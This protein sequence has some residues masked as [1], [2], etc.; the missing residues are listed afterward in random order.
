MGNRCRGWLASVIPTRWALAAVIA[1]AVPVSAQAPS[2]DFGV[3]MDSWHLNVTDV[4]G[5]R[6]MFV[7]VGGAPV[8]IGGVQAV[9]IPG[10]TV[11]LHGSRPAGGTRGSVLDHVAFHVPNVEGAVAR[12]WAAGVPIAHGGAR[13]PQA[14]ITTPDGLRIEV[15]ENAEQQ[16]PVR[17]HHVHWYVPEAAIPAAQTWYAEVFGAVPGMRRN[18]QAADIPGAN[19]TF[20]AAT[21]GRAPTRGRGLD[22]IGFKVRD[23]ASFCRRLEER[24]DVTLDRPC[25]ADLS[26]GEMRAGLVDPWGAYIELTD[27]R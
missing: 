11:Y 8:T 13:F 23:L 27:A 18:F 2:G 10:V 24:L 14:W 15:L 9:Q 7:A 26:T 17:H 1:I 5:A 12:W 21:E 3:T 6:E 4:I 20:A 25:Q 19:L 16:E 22:R